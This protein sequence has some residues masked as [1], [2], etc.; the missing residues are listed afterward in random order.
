M[1]KLLVVLLN[2]TIFVNCISQNTVIVIEEVYPN[3]NESFVDNPYISS[4]RVYEDLDLVYEIDYSYNGWQIYDSIVYVDNFD[5]CYLIE[6]SPAYDFE[7]RKVLYYELSY[8]IDC[9]M[10]RNLEDT[11]LTKYSDEYKLL[12]KYLIDIEELLRINPIQKDSTFCFEKNTKPRLFLN[13]GIPIDET[14][15]YFSYSIHERKI[16]NDRFVFE[17]YIVNRD[18][19][20]YNDMLFKVTITIELL[21]NNE[22]WTFKE[23][24]SYI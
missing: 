5:T 2:C 15:F 21:L 24:Y 4:K 1:K 7:R 11:N 20:Y 18:Y 6:Y 3:T 8:V 9:K 12:N 13:Y 17:N 16:C 19:I 14:I 22:I 10:Q 23:T